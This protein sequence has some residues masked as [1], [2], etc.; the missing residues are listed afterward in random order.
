MAS[1]EEVYE[2]L[3]GKTGTDPDVEKELCRRIAEIEST[4]G[5][6]ENLKKSDWALSWICIAV[7][8]FLPIVIYA[9]KLGITNI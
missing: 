1:Y 2:Q 7:G 6:V 4:D 9:I 8:T 3:Q 5:V